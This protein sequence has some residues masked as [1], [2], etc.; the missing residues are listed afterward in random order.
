MTQP[1]LLAAVL[2]SLDRI[3]WGEL[4]TSQKLDLA[5]VYQVAFNRLGP[6]DVPTQGRL[7]NKFD[8]LLPAGNAFLNAEIGQLLVY[9]QGASAAPKLV[10]LLENAPTQEEQIEY[11]RTLR[12]LKAG[13]TPQLREQYFR[14]FVKAAGYRGG[15]SFALFVQNIKKDALATLTPAEFAALKPIIDA[16]PPTT[17]TQAVAPPR[18]FVKEWKL[19]ELVDKAATGLKGRDFERGKAMF[20]AANCFSCHRYDNQGGALGPDLTSVAGRFS[21]RD[22]LE[23][24]ID[25]G[26]VISDQYAAVTILTED[27]VSVTGR[28]VNLNGDTMK[29]STNMLNPDE[30]VTI[31]RRKIEE[32]FPSKTSMMPNGLLNTLKEDEILDLVAYALSR[33]DRTHAMFAPQ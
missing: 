27:G 32:M 12:M 16:Q 4:S 22:L 24:I 29:I 18:P 14:W 15:A 25:P 33:G 20:A 30:Q 21:S 6:P 10:A 5:R 19:D 13:W 9:L 8:Q 3:D 11:A 23:S 17:I 28:I 26:K 1:E 31:D 7:I 2:K